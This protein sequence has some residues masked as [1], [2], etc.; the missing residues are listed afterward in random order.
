MT[1]IYK[2]PTDTLIFAIIGLILSF[3]LLWPIS[4]NLEALP[5]CTFNTRIF[6]N[7]VVGGDVINPPIVTPVDEPINP[8]VAPIPVITSTPSQVIPTNVATNFSTNFPVTNS[9]TNTN[10]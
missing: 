6:T 9:V 4:Y 1:S 5:N 2:L 7:I 10:N 8:I 3:I